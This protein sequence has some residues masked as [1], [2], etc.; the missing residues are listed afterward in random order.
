MIVQKDQELKAFKKI[1]DQEKKV[2]QA[3]IQK[4]SE[5]IK[6]ERLKVAIL[7]CLLMSPLLSKEFQKRYINMKEKGLYKVSRP[8]VE[9]EQRV[10]MACAIYQ[11][12]HQIV[13]QMRED[14]ANDKNQTEMWKSLYYDTKSQNDGLI[15]QIQELQKFQLKLQTQMKE[16]EQ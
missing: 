12:R 3:I 13:E 5:I 11:K 16:K 1:S 10:N 6:K 15:F 9:R 7:D 2:E 14:T 4:Q 8:E